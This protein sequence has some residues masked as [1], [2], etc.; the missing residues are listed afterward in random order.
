MLGEGAVGP[1]PMVPW[2]EAGCHGHKQK[3][4]AQLAKSEVHCTNLLKVRSA[5][6]R[7]GLFH[8]V[9]ATSTAQSV[10]SPEYCQKII[11]SSVCTYISIYIVCAVIKYLNSCGFP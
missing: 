10:K 9:L 11:F 6:E 7:A 1:D 5:E 4:I 2:V 8:S 3:S